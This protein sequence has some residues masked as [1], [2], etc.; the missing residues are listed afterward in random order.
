MKKNII[1][2]II[3]HLL[4]FAY[5]WTVLQSLPQLKRRFL[6]RENFI[7]DM[8]TSLILAQKIRRKISCCHTVIRL[9]IEQ[10]T[11]HHYL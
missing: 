4:L 3:V 2:I 9:R 11:Q 1:I 5:F 7:L 6:R 10:S 8:L